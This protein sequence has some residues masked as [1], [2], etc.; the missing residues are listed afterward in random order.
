MLSATDW[1]CSIPQQEVHSFEKIIMR[2]VHQVEEVEWRLVNLVD[3]V[4]TEGRP[5]VLLL[6]YLSCWHHVYQCILHSNKRS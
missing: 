6:A 5:E 1:D 4:S 2:L 3:Y